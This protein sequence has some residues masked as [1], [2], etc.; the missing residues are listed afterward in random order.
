MRALHLPGPTLAEGVMLLLWVAQLDTTDSQGRD[1][2]NGGR[3]A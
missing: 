2:L 3:V 1:F